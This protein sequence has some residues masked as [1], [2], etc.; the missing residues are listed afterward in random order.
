MPT[1]DGFTPDHPLPLFLAEHAEGP[2]QPGIGTARDK[3]VI[4]SRILKTSIL[5]VT[6][7]AI[8]I[9]ILSAGNPVVPFANVIAPLVDTS[10]LQ[11]GTGQID[12]NNSIN[13]RHSGFAADCRV[14][15][16]RDEIA[17]ASG[18]ADQSQTK[19]SEQSSPSNCTRRPPPERYGSSADR[20]T[21][22]NH[23]PI[24]RRS[25]KN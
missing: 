10:A 17:A 5:V 7:T 2:E 8:G 20:P 18:P 14:A 4:S 3:A 23:L 11:P 15:P 12:A 22:S 24:V 21:L 13:R 9:A 1:K 6:A 25:S 16:T 19:I